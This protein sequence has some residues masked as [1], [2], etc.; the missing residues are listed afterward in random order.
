MPPDALLSLRDVSRFYGEKPVF[1]NL[2]LELAPGLLYLVLGPNGAGKS[3]FLRLLAGLSAPD[4][5]KVER[6][7]NL[8]LSYLG[9]PTFIYPALTAI[10][11]LRFW[12]RAWNMT[13]NDEILLAALALVG[14]ERHAHE[15][16]R[17][18]SRG[19]AQR[20]NFA[21]CLLPNPELLLLDEPFTGMDARTRAALYAEIAA[22]RDAGVCVVLVSHIPESDGAL[23]D[24]VLTIDRRRLRAQDR[25]DGAC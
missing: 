19:M 25:S 20:L 8:R 21:R 23:A 11:N 24:V 14:L 4:S 18:F 1:R 3:T 15:Q 7:D 10:Q 5:G 12:A 16:A 13:A 6:R 9:H 22:R 2:D 17:V